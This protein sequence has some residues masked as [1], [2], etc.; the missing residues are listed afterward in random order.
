MVSSQSKR[1]K[2]KEVSTSI[3]TP[4]KLKLY[5]PFAVTA[6]TLRINVPECRFSGINAFSSAAGHL[7]FYCLNE[8]LGF[9]WCKE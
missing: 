6:R 8:Y 7:T 4:A 2:G 1:G 5:F 9:S 3:G